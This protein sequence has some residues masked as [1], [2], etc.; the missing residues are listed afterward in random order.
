MSDFRAAHYLQIPAGYC[1]SFGGLRWA[2]YGEA[3]EFLEGQAAGRTF[4]FA[5]EIA[6]FLEGLHGPEGELLC[7]GFVLHLLYLI[8]L[9]ERGARHGEGSVVCVERIAAP[10]RA[11]GCP[12]RNAGVLCAALCRSAPHSADPPELSALCEILTGGSW[13]PQMVLSHSILGVLDHAEEP[14]LGPAEFEDRFRRA[15]DSFGDGE[16]RHWLRH[17]RGPAETDGQRLTPIQP[18][19]LVETLAELEQRPRLAGIGRLVNRLEGALSLPPRRLACSLMQDGGYSDVTTKGAPEQILPIQFALEG[20]EFLRRFAEG[21]LLYFHREEPRQPAPQEMILLLDQ[22]VRTWGDVRLVLSGAAIALAR[23]AERRRIPIKLAATSNAGEAVDLTRLESR[24]LSALL[25]AS[26]MSQHPGA[27]LARTLDSLSA[28]E[29]DIVLFTH[30]KSLLE[31]DVAAAARSV[32]GQPG[33]RLFAVSVDSTGQLELA[34]I[35]RGLPVVLARSRITLAEESMTTVVASSTGQAA[36]GKAWRGDVEPIPFPF[37]C[38]ILDRIDAPQ[39]DGRRHFDF[40]EAGE[41]ILVIGR[42]GLLFCWRIDGTDSEI[43]PRPL[44]GGQVLR[45]IRTVVGVA[46]GFALVGRRRRNSV[47]AHYDFSTR[48]CNTYTINDAEP[49]DSWFYYRE[50]HCV[51]AQTANL[52]RPGPALDLAVRGEEAATTS[53]A[54]AASILA[55]VAPSPLIVRET[56][57][58]PADPEVD[59]QP[60]AMRLDS[61]TGTVQLQ[62]VAGEIRSLTPLRDGR[63]ALRGSHIVHARQGGDVIAVQIASGSA[64]GLYFLSLSRSIV[65]GTFFLGAAP[66]TGIFAL[67]RDG[68]RF[69]RT[70]DERGL[71]V[72][73]VPGAHP[74]VLVTHEESLW[75]HFATLGR[76]CLHVGEFAIGGPRCARFTCLIRWDRGRLEVIE[77]DAEA[78]LAQLG[79][80]VAV[81]RAVSPQ[82][83]VW[84]HDPN[85]FVQIVEHHGARILIDRYNHLAV[86]DKN[87]N[88]TCMFYVS[89]SEIAAWLP[90]GTRWGARRYLGGEPTPG[91]SERIAA[92]LTRAEPGEGRSS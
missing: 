19:S 7:F 30:R 34:E 11:L 47:L 71:E 37:H 51:A 25:E 4:A 3:I 18:R 22:G 12:L 81:S 59:T 68:Q 6:V 40:D 60:V 36:R 55:Q 61:R 89:G 29:R 66:G 75:N 86:L 32:A 56:A 20:E 78:L 26:D 33:A 23:Q 92:A 83:F 27:A 80:P 31:P 52:S 57:A 13:I 91:A 28:I 74:P 70:L 35:R 1:R 82:N 65:L 2:Q 39:D 38:G 87:G 8:G 43:L 69:A 84:G 9:G 64:P 46:G 41:R 5:A 72:R 58:F 73:D 45:P 53:R 15:A 77:P 49:T 79:G 90:D 67:S 88:L 44:V 48:S 21:E 54:R 10:F 85:R 63:P 17:G 24:A 14:A 62:G 76:S 50:L 42:F 16:I